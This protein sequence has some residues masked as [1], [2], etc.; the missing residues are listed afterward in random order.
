MSIT[1]NNI[2]FL[3]SLIK[4]R[5]GIS[6]SEEKLYLLES[7]LLPIAKKHKKENIE[8]LVNMLRAT[9]SEVIV[10][11]IIEAMTTNE[12]SFFRDTKPFEQFRDIAVPYLLKHVSNKKH[13]RI[14]SAAC[15]TGQEPYSIAMTLLESP[16]YKDFSFEI[17]ATDIASNVLEKAKNGLYSQ[18]EVQR[19]V[20][21]TSL[22]KYFTQEGESWRIK[23]NVRDMVTFQTC[24]LIDSFNQMGSF[25]IIFCRNVLIYFDQETK[26]HVLENLKQCLEPHGLLFLGCAESIFAQ[27][28]AFKAMEGGTGIHTLAK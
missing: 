4:E 9:P 3:I 10:K 17:V 12:S 24:N 15:S 22:I 11:N 23:D 8:S 18:F 13:F 25:D 7:R 28:V 27:T 19:G 5:S 1:L 21:I 16:Q 6:L 26:M 2:N 20:P 14:W